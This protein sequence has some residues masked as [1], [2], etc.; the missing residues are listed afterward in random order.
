MK[1]K[2]FVQKVRQEAKP[3]TL[4]SWAFLKKTFSDKKN[5]VRFGLAALAIVVAD[6][7]FPFGKVEIA[8]FGVTLFIILSYIALM[9]SAPFALAKMKIRHTVYTYGAYL[10]LSFTMLLFV[11]DWMLWYFETSNDHWVALYSLIIAVFNCIIEDLLK[12]DDH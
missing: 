10:W 8:G 7:L 3:A 6:Q 9:I 5:L 12:D 1:G 4:A 11:Y 2:E